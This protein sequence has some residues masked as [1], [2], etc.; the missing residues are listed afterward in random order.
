MRLSKRRNEA[1]VVTLTTNPSQKAGLERGLGQV[2][3]WPGPDCE[4]L[5]QKNQTEMKRNTKST[6][7][8]SFQIPL[9][10]V[11]LCTQTECVPVCVYM[12]AMAYM[13]VE[14]SCQA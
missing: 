5:S 11:G 6:K 12:Y 8:T 14:L 9:H 7:S 1:G 2:Q 4:I 3:S 10:M 13:G